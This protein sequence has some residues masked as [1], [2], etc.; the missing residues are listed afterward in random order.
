MTG[1]ELNYTGY[2]PASEPLREALCTLGNGFFGTRGAAPESRADDVHYPGTYIAGIYNRLTTHLEGQDIENESL[3]N[4]PNWLPLT[5]RVEDG[6]WFSIDDVEVLDYV[7]SLEI[8][9]GVLVRRVRFRD[10]DGRET[11]LSQRRIVHMACPHQ[12][13]LETTI[14]AEN[15]S[16]DVTVRSAIDGSVRNTGVARYRRL[17]DRH[18]DVVS[19]DAPEE[20]TVLLRA[21][22]VQSGIDVVEAARTRLWI[23]D[24]E[25]Q[26]ERRT[27]LE[28]PTAAQELSVRLEEG[29]TC[30]IEKV[31][32]LFTSRDLAISEPGSAAVVEVGHAATFA[33]MLERH[34][35]EWDDLWR[36][37]EVF[38]EG[39]ERS[40]EVLNLHLFHLLQVASPNTT[41]LDVGIPA[42]G[43]HGEAYRGHIFWDELFIFPLL[44][45]RLPEIARSLLRYRERRL[46]AARLAAAEAGLRGAMFPWQS[47]SSGREESQVVH[48]NP[49]SGRW[50]PDDSHRQRH[51]GSAIAYN[52]W[53]FFQVT[54]DVDFLVHSGV[55]LFIEIAR[56]WASMAAYDPID[57]RYDICGVVGPDEFHDH[58]PNW[59]GPGLRNNA[60]TNVMAA[61]VLMHAPL[62]L[63]PVAGMQREGLVDRL[64]IVREELELWDDISHKIRVPFHDGGIISQFQGYEALEELDWIGYCERYGDIQ[65]LDRILEAEDDSVN[66]YKASKQADVLM[67]FYLLSV[68]ELGSLFDRLGYRFDDEMLRRNIDYYL[69]RTSHGSTLSQVVHSWVLARSDRR[70]SLDLFRRSLE[71][72]ISDIQGG[73]TPEGIHLGAMAGTVD[74][75][76]RGYG[77]MEVRDGVLHFK[78]SVPEGIDRIEFRIYYR[79]RWITVSLEDGHLRLMSEQ[80][81]RP[82]V[83][84]AFHEEV[85]ELGSGGTVTFKRR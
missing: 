51:I 77:G 66:R 33:Q 59:E 72:D 70:K 45:Y 78:P 61:W 73:T 1:W 9:R 62:V 17:A 12:A 31:V 18:L 11:A 48:L 67:L 60:Y 49:R 14:R 44:N 23:D 16:G 27:S 26:V 32:A 80:T 69:Q 71:S 6:P 53:Q 21:R 75:A 47:G 82:P 36:R 79:H 22:T 29:S 37:F 5:F 50:I 7:L 25:A 83:T 68:E 24:E 40:P 15:W 42:R 34:V 65:R 84:V 35:L 63:E 55:E 74:L 39:V 10:G 3:V 2:D 57:D 76:G 46:P 8:R 4:V 64:G 30:R 20:D 56:F 52:V 13:A 19:L 41:D 81:A 28:A 54:Q 58:D 43:L 38:V 85:A